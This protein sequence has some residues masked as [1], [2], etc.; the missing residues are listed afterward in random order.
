MFSLWRQACETYAQQLQEEPDA[1][2]L[3]AVT[4]LLVCHKV[5]ESVQYL[6]DQQLFR[7]AFVLAKARSSDADSP[8]VADTLERWAKY[9]FLQGNFE[10]AACW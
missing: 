1:D 3:E 7:E 4:Y 9:S 10:Q 2:P 8:L 6:C 5:S